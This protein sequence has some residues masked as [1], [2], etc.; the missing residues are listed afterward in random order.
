MVIVRDRD[1]LLRQR[2]RLAGGQSA[3]KAR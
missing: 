1:Q 2:R 3:R